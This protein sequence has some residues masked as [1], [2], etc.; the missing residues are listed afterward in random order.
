M[1]VTNIQLRLMAGHRLFAGI[2]ILNTDSQSHRQQGVANAKF[3]PG[4]EPGG[5]SSTL[6]RTGFGFVVLFLRRLGLYLFG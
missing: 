1:S 4:F 2:S 5:L 6:Q 3:E